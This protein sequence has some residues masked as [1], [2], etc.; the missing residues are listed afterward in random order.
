LIGFT[1]GG[2]TISGSM[3]IVMIFISNIQMG[4]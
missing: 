3:G 1:S 2:K 4:S